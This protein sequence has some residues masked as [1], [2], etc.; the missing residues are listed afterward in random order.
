MNECQYEVKRMY[1]ADGINRSARTIAKFENLGDAFSW[2]KFMDR[3]VNSQKKYRY[4]LVT[5]TS[6]YRVEDLPNRY[7]DWHD[8]K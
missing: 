8:F 4:Y 2:A 5:L 7:N 1:V 3:T 6:T